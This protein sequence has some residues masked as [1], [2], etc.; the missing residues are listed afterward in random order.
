M[1]E[2]VLVKKKLVENFLGEIFGENVWWKIEVEICWWKFLEEMPYLISLNPLLFK[3]N[4]HWVLE[5][6]LICLSLCLCVIVFL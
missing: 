2:I 5:A 1:M 4:I 3:K 6:L